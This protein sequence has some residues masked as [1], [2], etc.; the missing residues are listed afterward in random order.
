LICRREWS[1]QQ[2]GFETWLTALG[3]YDL[4]AM[5]LGDGQWSWLV[6]RGSLGIVEGRADSLAEAQQAAEAAVG[7]HSLPDLPPAARPRSPGC[8]AN[9]RPSGHWGSVRA[10]WAMW[11]NVTFWNSVGTVLSI[12]IAL[13]AAGFTGMQWYLTNKADKPELLTIEAALSGVKRP[14]DAVHV[15]WINIGERPVRQGTATLF[16]VSDDGNRYEKF[17]TS[18]IAPKTLAPTSGQGGV[19]INNLD[20]SRFL[21][22]FLVCVDYYDDENNR[23][24]QSFLFKPGPTREF[25]V[26]GPPGIITRLDEQLSSKHQVCPTQR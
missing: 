25:P 1:C 26:P 4:S 13:A 8:S 16:T 18:E 3:A 20:M 6:R 10:N 9:A 7:G 24:P 14:P 15:K 5:N 22:L 23:Y 11:R 12:L 17:G 21:G 19:E 2:G